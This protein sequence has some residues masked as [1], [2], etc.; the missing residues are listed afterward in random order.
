ME[1][2]Q[3]TTVVSPETISGDL[4]TNGI[5]ILEKELDLFKPAKE[6][7]KSLE[8]SIEALP[9][10]LDITDKKGYNSVKELRLSI[11]KIRLAVANKQSNI[12]KL[13]KESAKRFK[14]GADTIVLRLEGYESELQMRQDTVDE[15]EKL[16]KAKEAEAKAEAERIAAAEKAAIEAKVSVRRNTLF[17]EKWTY[18]PSVGCYESPFNEFQLLNESDFATMSDAEFEAQ[19]S[20]FRADKKAHEDKQAELREIAERAA[21]AESDR[22]EAERLQA[23]KVEAD[24]LEAERLEQVRLQEA[25][26]EADRLEAEAQAH[27]EAQTAQSNA[28]FAELLKAEQEATQATETAGDADESYKLLFPET[29]QGMAKISPDMSEVADTLPE[30]I[31][32]DLTEAQKE[33]IQFP[34]P[35]LVHAIASASSN[36]ESYVPLVTTPGNENTSFFSSMYE[37]R[38]KDITTLLFMHIEDVCANPTIA[39][40]DLVKVKIK[41]LSEYAEAISPVALID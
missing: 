7:Y 31:N 41:E 40:L 16:Q 19:L 37:E 22:L 15:H 25:K 35:S 14:A 11:R 24:R 10:V 20:L 26:A 13:I 2:T 33:A 12:D 38:L 27:R 28:E 4:V 34:K 23:A 30:R 6:V 5:A 9:K 21:K 3:P 1:N 36:T 29:F 32:V 39:N 8:D 17:A 18:N